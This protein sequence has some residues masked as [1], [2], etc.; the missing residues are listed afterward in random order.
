[1]ASIDKAD[2]RLGFW[3]AVGFALFGLVTAA[4]QFALARVRRG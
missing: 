3:I 1:M 2:I 4:V